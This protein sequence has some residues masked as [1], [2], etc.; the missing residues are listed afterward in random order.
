LETK[1]GYL[2]K[3]HAKRII[4]LRSEGLSA[5]SVSNMLGISF[6]AVDYYFKKIGLT[7]TK[8]TFKLNVEGLKER[9][10]NGEACENCGAPTKRTRLA[11]RFCSDRCRT[12]WWNSQRNKKTKERGGED[13]DW[14]RV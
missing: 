9:M 3:Y 4:K 13:E 8:I 2:I 1:D 7:G 11:R 14:N 12:V 6:Q 10:A 5:K